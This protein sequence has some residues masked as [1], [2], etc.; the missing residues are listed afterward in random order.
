[1]AFDPDKTVKIVAELITKQVE[2]YNLI[3][4]AQDQRIA[5]VL[6]PWSAPLLYEAGEH[7]LEALA[8]LAAIAE[9]SEQGVLAHPIV[10]AADERSGII[11][12]T[13][14]VMKRFGR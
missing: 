5:S 6:P 3:N 9:M 2:A 4:A 7:A 11:A 13:R 10:A 1:M 8:H 12:R 14:K